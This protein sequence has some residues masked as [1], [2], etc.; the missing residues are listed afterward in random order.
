MM[1][2]RD[3]ADACAA[4]SNQVSAG[5]P[6]TEVVS[7]MGRLQ[8]KYGALWHEAHQVV[9]RGGTLSSAL[10]DAWPEIYVAT[11][12]A[13]EQSGRMEAVCR[14]IDQSIE[15]QASAFSELNKLIYPAIILVA[16]LSMSTFFLGFVIPNLMKSLDSQ[17]DPSLILQFGIWLNHVILDNWISAAIVAGSGVVTLAYWIASGKAE[18]SFYMFLLKLP[19]LGEKSADIF[20]AIWGKTLSLMVG[21]GMPIMSAMPMSIATMPPALQSSIRRVFH[22]LAQNLPIGR[23]VEADMPGDDRERIPFYLGNAFRIAE[24]TGALD[25][26]LDRSVPIL[27]RDTK[28]AISRLSSTA[29]YAAMAVSGCLLAVPIGAYYI[30]FLKAIRRMM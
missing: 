16:G 24:Q 18:E 6:L 19:Y 1:K 3:I 12:K 30:E 22:A 15:L 10:K 13:G 14:E 9:Y 5:I 8:P 20:F 26:E 25:V 21:A 4:L 7:R 17:R 23:A 11:L 29:N 28:R 27:I 2:Q